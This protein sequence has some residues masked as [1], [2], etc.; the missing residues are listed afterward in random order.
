MNSPLISIIIPNCNRENPI[1]ETLQSF[2]DQDYLN[3]ECII[4]DDGSTDIV[5]SSNIQISI[6]KRLCLIQ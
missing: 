5:S 3:W 2:I 6:R 1:A 4:V